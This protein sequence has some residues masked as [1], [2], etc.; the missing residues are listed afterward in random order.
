MSIIPE[1]SSRA[2][3]VNF[4]G[5]AGAE[6]PIIATRK[7]ESTITIKDGFTLA[8]GGLIEKNTDKTH[9]K[10]PVL[11]DLPGMGKLFRSKNDTITH[12]NLIIFITAKTLNP[13]GSSYKDVFSP[14]MLNTMGIKSSDVPGHEVPE[15]ES[16]LYDSIRVS[17]DS[18]ENLRDEA[19]LEKQLETLEQLKLYEKRK[20]EEEAKPSKRKR[21]HL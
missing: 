3:S 4:G 1:V 10:V 15:P 18:L 5:S 2:G 20:Q 14:T 12:R 21:L 8:I 13:D 19:K 17:R 11:G 6:I 9:T 7:T 16:Q